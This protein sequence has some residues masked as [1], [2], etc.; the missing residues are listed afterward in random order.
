MG[1]NA[2]FCHAGIHVNRTLLYIHTYMHTYI[3][4]FKKTTNN[5]G[6]EISQWFRALTVLPEVLS[7]IP[8]NH[9][10]MGSDAL[11]WCV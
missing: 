8:S 11:F 3:Q 1:S 2:L 6:L 10:V 4:T 9:M 7:S 5:I